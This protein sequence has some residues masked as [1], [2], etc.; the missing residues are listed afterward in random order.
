MLPWCSGLFV[1]DGK[2]S[3]DPVITH[4]GAGRQGHS[5]SDPDPVAKM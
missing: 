5:W 4:L 3:G 2:R 1:S